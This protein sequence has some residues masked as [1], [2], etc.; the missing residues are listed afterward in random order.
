MTTVLLRR[1]PLC[2]CF[3]YRDA[4]CQRFLQLKVELN[5]DIDIDKPVESALCFYD[6]TIILEICRCNEHQLH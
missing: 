5:I 4:E 1:N 3:E 2:L 6:Y